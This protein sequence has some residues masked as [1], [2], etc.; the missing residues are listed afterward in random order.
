MSQVI[1]ND[2]AVNER[3]NDLAEKDLNGLKMLVVTLHPATKPTEAQLE[4]YFHNDNHISDIA[5]DISVDPSKAE[6]LFSLHG[7][8]RLTAG[9]GI[10]QV[11]VT[12]AIPNDNGTNGF[13]LTVEPIGD[14]STYTLE[15]TYSPDSIDPFFAQLN[16]KFRPGCFT[17]DCAPAWQPAP[18][19]QPVP[20][21]DYLAKDYDSFRHTLMTAMMQR[22]P[23]WQATSEADHDQVLI[24]LFAAAADE[25]SDYQDRVMNEAYLATARKRVSLARHARLMDYHIHQGNQASTW[26]ALKLKKHTAQ[27]TLDDELMAWTGQDPALSDAVYFATR[28]KYAAPAERQLLDWQFNAFRLHTWSGAQPALRAGSTSAD[29][30]PDVSGGQTKANHLCDMIE[31]GTLRYLLV[32]EHLNPLTGRVPGRDPRKRQLLRLKTGSGSAQVIHDPLEDIWLVRVQWADEDRLR[33]DYS[34]TTFCPD[35]KVERVSLFHGNLLKMHHGLPVKTHFYAAGNELPIDSEHEKYRHYKRLYRYGD[36]KG[37]TCDL[38]FTH[39]AYLPTPTGGD[40]PPQSTLHVEVDEPGVGTDVWNEV[41]NLVH[42]DDSKEEGSHFV[43]ETDELHHSLL[44]FGNGVNGS[45]LPDGAVV[46]CEYQIGA[47]LEGN[48]GHD[49]LVNF[50]TPAP[51]AA[52]I[53]EVWNPFDVT[54]GRDPEPATNILRNAPEAY[55]VHQLRAVTLADYIGR[56]EEVPGISR[57]VASY[58]WTGSWRTVRICL[59]PEGTT[60]LKPK[61]RNAV[62]A[63]LETVRLIGEDL[64]L[65]P[66]RFVPLKIEISLCVQPAYWCEDLRYVLEQEFSDGYTP[67]GR[68]G[69]F[70]PD[71]WTFGQPLHRSQIEGRIQQVTGVE[72]IVSIS[73]RRFNG[74]APGTPDP[75]VLEAAFDEVFEVRN[76]PDH[77]EL[78][79]I[80][81]ELQGG[82]Q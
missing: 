18:A 81:F 21:I 38:P 19:P 72:H 67:D 28:E 55:A 7:G 59:D 17:N 48:V 44:R 51:H 66:P 15:L 58:A 63:H 50:Q 82:R 33:F 27:F 29:I 39:L 14:Y 5:H 1:H 3:A 54:D 23:G 45:L 30:V 41:I 20:A 65:R 12:K 36:P 22:V 75:E 60:E 16:F 57:A 25:L 70:N 8:H 71:E 49:T 37:S 26:L 46:H 10:G 62:A 61:L 32:Q 77:L 13:R 73:M 78:G 74:P 69:F 43:V 31:V 64:E 2:D 40:V 11:K 24:D 53:T 6:V 52:D 9:P 35:G 80:Y 68:R 56:A 79:S 34:F 47:G 76:D 4:V 42:S